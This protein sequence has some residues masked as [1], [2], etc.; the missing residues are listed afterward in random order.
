M[1]CKFDS[2]L[3]VSLVMYFIF[4][5]DVTG[6]SPKLLQSLVELCGEQLPTEEVKLFYK[7]L[8]RLPALCNRCW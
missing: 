5:F 4:Q 6:F 1:Y 2:S 8:T 7:E 3:E